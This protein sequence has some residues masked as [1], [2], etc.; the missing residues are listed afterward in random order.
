M[1]KSRK[2]AI[3]IALQAKMLVLTFNGK[4]T[5]FRANKF[6]WKGTIKP[7]PLCKEYIVQVTYQKGKIPKVYIL[8]PLLQTLENAEPNHLYSDGSLCLFYPKFKEWQP[9]DFIY[10]TIIPWVSEWL[11]HYEIWLF[12]GKWNGGGK[13]PE[14]L[15]R[16]K[17]KRIRKRLR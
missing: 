7:L 8:Y 10:K 13:H 3:N 2:K 4:I 15:S 11:L 14:K 6:I 16:K 17:K 12:T 5:S 1:V 9:S